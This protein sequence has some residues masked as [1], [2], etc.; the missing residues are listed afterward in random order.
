MRSELARL[1][2]A[3]TQLR[4]FWE[5]AA[6]RREFQSRLGSPVDIS[7]IRTLRAIERSGSSGSSVADVAGALAV[8]ASTASRLV[9]AVVAK[10]FVNRNS[11]AEDKRRAQLFLT[12][13]GTNLLSSANRIRTELLG[14]ITEGW[15]H[16]DLDALAALLD[17]LGEAIAGF[18]GRRD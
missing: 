13:Q 14:E 17:R 7:L 1:D 10:E 5:G 6:I 3:V 9:N 16:D 11:S 2:A 4:R 8:D 12:V 18:E 15:S